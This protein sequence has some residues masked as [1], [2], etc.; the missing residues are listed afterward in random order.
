MTINMIFSLKKVNGNIECYIKSYK[1]KK[2]VVKV[3]T[4]QC[5]GT[6]TFLRL[7]LRPD[8]VGSGS[9]QKKAAPVLYN[10]VTFFILSS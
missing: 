7:R 4:W 3:T 8:W 5:C 9:R 6:A 2:Y 1:S 10:T